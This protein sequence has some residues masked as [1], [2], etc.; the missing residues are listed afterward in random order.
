F[1]RN[2]KIKRIPISILEEV[3]HISWEE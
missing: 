1:Y 2:S 3:L